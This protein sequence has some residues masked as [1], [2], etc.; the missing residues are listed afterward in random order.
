MAFQ[1][2]ATIDTATAI[3]RERAAQHD[4][5]PYCTAAELQAGGKTVRFAAC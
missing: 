2:E 5:Q 4:V 3:H 1:R